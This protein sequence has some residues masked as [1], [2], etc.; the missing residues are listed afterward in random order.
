MRNSI[1]GDLGEAAV[2]QRLLDSNR[3]TLL[4]EQIQIT[5]P[6]V[7]SHRV[8]DFLV[9]SNKTGKLSIIEVKTGNATR[10]SSQLAKDAL[11]ADPT[12][13]TLFRGDRLSPFGFPAGTPTPPIITFEVNASNLTR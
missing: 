8:T 12:V 7:G 5:T 2:R 1:Q 11:I 9:Q 10:S 6:G 3:L 4:G 13:P